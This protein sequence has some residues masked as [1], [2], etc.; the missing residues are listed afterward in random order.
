MLYISLLLQPMLT[1]SFVVLCNRHWFNR[2]P[3]GTLSTHDPSHTPT[4]IHNHNYPQ[5]TPT[6]KN[7][8]SFFAGSR[9]VWCLH[10]HM[11]IHRYIYYG[12]LK[13]KTCGFR[14]VFRPACR[15]HFKRRFYCHYGV[16]ESVC[17]VCVCVCVWVCVC[18][19][20]QWSVLLP[21]WSP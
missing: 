15:E 20:L 16:P 7:N 10:V 14:N 2:V 18:V 17:C 4:R 21:L 1:A 9:Y 12:N 5:P 11:Y 3:G 8:C 6:Q 19:S 13:T